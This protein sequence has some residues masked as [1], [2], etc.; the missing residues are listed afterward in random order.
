MKVVNFSLIYIEDLSKIEDNVIAD[1]VIIKHNTYI[2]QYL[3][4]YRTKGK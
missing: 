4:N 2:S 1:V 3:E